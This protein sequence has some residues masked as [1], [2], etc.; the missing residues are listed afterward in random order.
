MEHMGLAPEI[1]SAP[2]DHKIS[3]IS[4]FTLLQIPL[5]YGKQ[6]LAFLS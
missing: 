4:F 3:E 6:G 5:R 2:L 1:H